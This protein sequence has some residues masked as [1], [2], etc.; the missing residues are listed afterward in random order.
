MGDFY[1]F[2]FNATGANKFEIGVQ[3]DNRSN[4]ID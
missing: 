1:S 3:K 2:D 4:V